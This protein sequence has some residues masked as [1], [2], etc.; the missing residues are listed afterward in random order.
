[1]E[2][3]WTEATWKEI[4]DAVLAEVGKVRAAQKVFP[5]AHFENS[6]VQ[7]PD[8]L[9]NFQNLSIQEGQ[10]KPFVEIFATFTL[11]STQV[12]QEPDQKTGKTLARMAAKAL[13]LAEDTYF[14]Q[15]SSLVAPRTPG[16][17]PVPP[18]PN[19]PVP[20]PVLPANTQA[21]NWRVGTDLG[22]LAAA[23]PADAHVN[24]PTRVAPPLVV[25]R[26]P[27]N[28]NG[29]GAVWGN[30]TFARVAQAITLLVGKAQAAPYALIL[31]T[32]PYAD[33]FIPP[34]P[35]SLVTTADRI[36]PLVEGGFY[37]SPVLPANEG[38]LVA[39]AGD[40]VQLFVGRE[41][42]TEFV[43]RQGNNY[44]FRVV[45]RVQYVVRDPRALVLLQFET[46]AQAANRQQQA[47][48]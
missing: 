10:T 23:N 15:L 20:I 13:A 17:L 5:T 26:A 46:E 19:A 2:V 9:I 40:P 33:T 45:E 31:P 39:L 24:D 48:A 8:E 35:D 21:E 44:V 38:L 43:V 18:N 32:E 16:P 4:N 25:R 41:V 47:Q 1:M 28:P 22:L 27:P 12:K 36:R 37:T 30:N 3:D 11:T 7:I 14:F 34:S 29:N 42:S 6:P